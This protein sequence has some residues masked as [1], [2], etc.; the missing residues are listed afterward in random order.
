MSK[1]I[2]ITRP[3]HSNMAIYPGNP[4]VSL[5][6]AVKAGEA[7]SA[8]TEISM[9]SHAGTHIDAPSH[10]TEGA[11]GTMSYALDYMIG[12]AQVVAINDV[13]VIS[14]TD[15]PSTQTERLI[16]KTSNSDGD[17]NVFDPDFVALDES[18]AEELVKRNIKVVGIDGPSIKKKSVRD[19]VHTILLD[20]G[21]VI[22]EGLWLAA[23]S[24]GEYELLCLPLPVDLD[25]APARV[26]LRTP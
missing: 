26:V 10:I 5:K 20:A 15:I 14:A 2:D 18:A 1:I 25:G 11:S 6:Q 17:S 12:S 7:T 3:I 8:L 9:G 13:S 19:R 16:I 23:V 22:I 4:P 21:A 24:P